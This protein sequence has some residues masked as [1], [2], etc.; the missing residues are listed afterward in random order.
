MQ[1]MQKSQHY[2]LRTVLCPGCGH[3]QVLKFKL[4]E[5]QVTER[6]EACGKVA[7]F[8]RALSGAEAWRSVR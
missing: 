3:P 5:V 7:T 1:S 2:V 6:C 8:E 4:N